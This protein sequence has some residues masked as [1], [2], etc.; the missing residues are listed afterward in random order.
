MLLATLEFGWQNLSRTRLADAGEGPASR[1][2]LLKLLAEADRAETALIVLRIASQMALVAILVLLAQEWVPRWWPGGGAARPVVLAALTSFV[3]ITLFCR[4]LPAE[5]SVGVLEA[6]VRTTMPVIIVLGRLLSPPVEIVRKV[7][8]IAT[9]AT[10]QAEAELYADEILAT[11][12]EGEREGHLA[13]HQA[14][15]IEKILLLQKIE[16]RRLMTPRTDVDTIDVNVTVG[17]AR[18]AALATGRSRYPVVEDE[19][20]HVVGIVHVKDLLKQGLEQPVRAAMRPPWFVPESKFITELLAEFRKHKTHLAVVL[21]E[22]GG[23]SGVITIEDVLEEIVGEIEDEFDTDEE[24]EE[25]D[26]LDSRHAVAPGAMRVDEVNATLAIAIP[27]SDDWDTLG[28]FIFNTLGRL[29]TEGEILRQ[30]NLIL[31]V[32]NVV[33]RRIDRVAIEI[34]EPVV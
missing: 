12:E 1:D 11:V 25:I 27:E 26:I 18:E 24:P 16:V 28:G 22:Y 15:M 10:K 20:D 33:E 6:L 7:F 3:W 17:E 8:R 4:V 34:L 21:D 32:E 29:P 30:D 9:G 5:L 2:R 31:T 13:E 23:T 14:D 19:V